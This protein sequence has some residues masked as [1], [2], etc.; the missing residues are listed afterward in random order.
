LLRQLGK[1][2]DPGRVFGGKFGAYMDVSIR[3]DGPVTLL[4]EL[5]PTKVDKK[6]LKKLNK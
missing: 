4:I 6:L 5:D 1:K 3:N 2:Y